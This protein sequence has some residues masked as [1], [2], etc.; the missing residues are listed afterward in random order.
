MN[1]RS[2][3]LAAVALLV[4]IGIGVLLRKD[5]PEAP[6]PGAPE[7]TISS[8]RN[9][10]A[11][12]ESASERA[13][14]SKGSSTTADRREE[15]WGSSAPAARKPPRGGSGTPQ[16][17]PSRVDS[18]PREARQE[19][20]Y[21]DE[22]FGPEEPGLPLPLFVD[23]EG[24]DDDFERYGDGPVSPA[25]HEAEDRGATESRPG[26]DIG[27]ESG[28][29]GCLPLFSSCRS[30]SDCCSGSVCRSRPGTISGS[31]ECTAD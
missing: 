25:W 8:A 7:Q 22:T 13:A 29:E 17:E 31:F 12:D 26:E 9:S 19:R 4:G 30:D 27:G 10:D 2:L 18:R 11:V 14:N 6:S 3:V 21:R 23:E 1:S 20:V 5:P 16:G 24:A 28:V 15:A